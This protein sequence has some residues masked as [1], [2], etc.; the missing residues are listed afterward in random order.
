MTPIMGLMK[1]AEFGMDK[2]G[3]RDSMATREKQLQQQ[4]DAD[5]QAA[6]GGMQMGP[7]FVSEEQLQ[8]IERDSFDKVMGL[9]DQFS[10]V[11]EGASPTQK[12][13]TRFGVLGPDEK[14]QSMVGLMEMMAMRKG[15]PK[16]QLLEPT[17]VPN[18]ADEAIAD[19][20]SNRQKMAAMLG[21]MG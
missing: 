7:A 9:L 1:L 16:A 14:P 2:M 12:L 21:G 15:Q 5:F 3:I 8:G 18:L 4:A 20:Q 19:A 17:P 6:T 10:S 13:L 11:P